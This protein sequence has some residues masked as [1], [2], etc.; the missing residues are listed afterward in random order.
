MLNHSQGFI[1]RRQLLQTAGGG[2]GSWA[3]SHLFNADQVRAE[4]EGSARLPRSY[5]I[6]KPLP[7]PLFSSLPTA[8]Q[9]RWICSTTNPL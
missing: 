9:V 1:N 5:R 2:I 4:E 3:L 6:I 7:N 8:A